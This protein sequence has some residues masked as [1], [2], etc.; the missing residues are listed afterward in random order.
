MSD[1]KELKTLFE[2]TKRLVAEKKL[3]LSSDEDLSLAVMNLI[4]IE[5]HFYFSGSKTGQSEYYDLIHPIRELRKVY[6]KQL[7]PDYEGEVW[8]L[9]KHLLA[10]SMRLIEVGTKRQETDRAAAAQCFKHAFTLYSYFWTL[11]LKMATR[12]A[13]GKTSGALPK[14]LTPAPAGKQQAVEEFLA[15]LVDCCGE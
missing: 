10:A 12:G 14:T 1:M 5:E 8:C 4:S 2:E 11:K 7:L 3:D 15:K 13:V 6:L 9:C